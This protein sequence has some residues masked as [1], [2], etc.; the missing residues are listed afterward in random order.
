MDNVLESLFFTRFSN[1]K[2]VDHSAVL[3]FIAR[4]FCFVIS[5]DEI[6]IMEDALFFICGEAF[7]LI[8]AFDHLF[9]IGGVNPFA[10][11]K[12]NGHIKSPGEF[13][14]DLNGRRIVDYTVAVKGRIKFDLTGFD[15]ER[16]LKGF[17]EAYDMGKILQIW[18]SK[19]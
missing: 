13:Y 19:Q 14:N 2:A 7:E 8:E 4:F 17:G 18:S 12:I 9:I 11:Q 16:A 3:S 10:E 1:K 5:D 6:H 15:F